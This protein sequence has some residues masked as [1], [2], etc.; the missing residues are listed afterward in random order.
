MSMLKSF[1][2]LPLLIRFILLLIPGLN[3]ITEII[4]RA[5]VV[6]NGGKS[7]KQIIVLILAI[8]PPTGV[9]LGWVDLFASLVQGKVILS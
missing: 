6:L 2:K 8:I 4:L 5:S 1:N 3:W 7:N 9:L